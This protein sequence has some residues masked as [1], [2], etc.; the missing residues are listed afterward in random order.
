MVLINWLIDVNKHFT[1]HVTQVCQHQL[2]LFLLTR[3]IVHC[4]LEIDP[5][6]IPIERAHII[7]TRF[8]N[9]PIIMQFTHY[10]HRELIL[11]AFRQKRKMTQL[12]VRIGEDF[13]ERVSKARTG[14]YQLMKNSIEQGKT[15]FFKSDK[16]VVDGDY[17]MFDFEQKK[18]IHVPK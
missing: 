9:R 14:L 6:D 18:P 8:G 3:I 2:Q 4:T 5:T 12:Q 13:P 10:K 17:F 1:S 11:K 15:A 16:L 7:P